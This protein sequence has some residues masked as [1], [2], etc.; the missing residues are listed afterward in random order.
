MQLL[1]SIRQILS[2]VSSASQIPHLA[3]GELG[4]TLAAEYLKFVGYTL[5]AR[6]FKLPRGRNFHGAVVHAEIDIIGYDGR[7]LCFVEVK[8]RRSDYFASPEVNVGLQK[9][10][11]IASA[12]RL[13]RRMFRI[14]NL[15]FRYDVITILIPENI[16]APNIYNTQIEL[17]RG[18]WTDAKFKKKRWFEITT[19]Y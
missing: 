7:L 6:N 19:D 13:Y 1:R 8:T 9:Q 15:P 2:P 11:Q 14:D 5:V 17:L 4:E 10:R 3:L 16:T 12:A 18:F